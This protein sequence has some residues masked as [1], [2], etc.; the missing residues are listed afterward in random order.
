M[1][2]TGRVDKRYRLVFTA[3][4]PD[5]SLLSMWQQKVTKVDYLIA[6]EVWF[7]H[8][9]RLSGFDV[10]HDFLERRA[11]Y[12]ESAFINDTD[13]DPCGRSVPLSDITRVALLDRRGRILAEATRPVL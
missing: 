8:I 3:V 11:V 13:V 4:Q 5:G 2:K 7:K 1:S 12:I 9:Q 10:G 6:V